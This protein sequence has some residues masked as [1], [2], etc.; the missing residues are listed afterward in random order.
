MFTDEKLL[1]LA[2]LNGLDQMLTEHFVECN[3]EELKRGAQFGWVMT[4]QLPYGM[5]KSVVADTSKDQEQIDQ[6]FINYYSENFKEN[7]KDHLLELQYYLPSPLRKL[8]CEAIWAFE[9]DK[10]IICIPV[11][12]SVLEGALVDLSNGT[13]RSS[14][15][16]RKGIDDSIRNDDLTA[17]V[18]P[19]ISLSWFLDFAFRSV[20]F[21][22]VGF[23][24]L[25][26]HWAQHGRYLEMLGDKPVFQLFSAVALILFIYELKADYL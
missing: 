5:Y 1:E 2:G 8:L 6:F 10:K 20:D 19:L 4:L 21:N 26:R 18:I 12:F 16:Y 24:E 9:N 3:G 15:R 13:N 23:T 22:Q 14:V 17:I 11:L 25:N 7:L